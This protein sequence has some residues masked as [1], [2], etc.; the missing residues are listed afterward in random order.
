V[1][2]EGN[3]GGGRT[4]HAILPTTA[5]YDVESIRKGV[6]PSAV[7]VVRSAAQHASAVS[8]SGT[9]EGKRIPP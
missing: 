6:K 1:P 5:V 4:R 3:T 7:P 9:Q 8:F 2:Q